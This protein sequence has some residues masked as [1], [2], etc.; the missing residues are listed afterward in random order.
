MLAASSPGLGFI[1]APLGQEVPG[2]FPSEINYAFGGNGTYLCPPDPQFNTRGEQGFYFDTALGGPAIPTDA[3]LATVYGYTPVQA[4]WVPSINADG[5]TTYYPGPWRVPGG[6]NPAGAYGPQPSLSGASS[7]ASPWMTFVV[8]GV[9]AVAGWWG[10][11]Q[12]K[13]PVA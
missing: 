5:T 7:T 6:W 12:F 13:K 11:K 9:L 4:G 2:Q 8:I 10:Y 1:I 3:E